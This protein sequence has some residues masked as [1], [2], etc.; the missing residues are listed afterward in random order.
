MQGEIPPPPP[1]REEV[2]IRKLDA[3]LEL[4]DARIRIV[5]PIPGQ[6]RAKSAVGGDAEGSAEGS[7][8]SEKDGKDAV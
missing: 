5:T 6:S 4:T 3:L 1:S 8:A 2:E 7:T